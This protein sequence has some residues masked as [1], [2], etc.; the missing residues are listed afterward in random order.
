MCKDHI[1]KT[2][3]YAILVCYAEN[4]INWSYIETDEELQFITNALLGDP[5]KGYEWDLYCPNP[6]YNAYV[7]DA[8]ELLIIKTTLEECID[9][10]LQT[11]RDMCMARYIDGIDWNED[12]QNI[13]F[14]EY[15]KPF[16]NNLQK[17]IQS[18]NFQNGTLQEYA[19]T[20]T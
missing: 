19:A 9:E 12:M 6:Q 13:S 2:P 1:M 5:T 20:I 3:C 14:N 18:E 10:A 8:D 11:T 4:T 15:L 16:I 7:V 17:E